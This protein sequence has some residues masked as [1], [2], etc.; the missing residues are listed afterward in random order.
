MVLSPHW[1]AL[2][3]QFNNIDSMRHQT[4]KSITIAKGFIRYAYR[5]LWVRIISLCLFPLDTRKEP[6]IQLHFRRAFCMTPCFKIFFLL[7][8][9]LPPM[10]HTPTGDIYSLHTVAPTYRR[11]KIHLISSYRL[12]ALRSSRLLVC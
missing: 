5:P 10:M 11:L 1:M 4:H 8:Y 2:Q 6:M 9:E 3:L 7:G 12:A